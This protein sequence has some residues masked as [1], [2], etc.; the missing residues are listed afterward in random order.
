MQTVTV[1]LS[2]YQ[3]RVFIRMVNNALRFAKKSSWIRTLEDVQR[4]LAHQFPEQYERELEDYQDW[5]STM[6]E[7]IKPE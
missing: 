4:E 3:L 1:K 2:E 7:Q 5:Q 6:A